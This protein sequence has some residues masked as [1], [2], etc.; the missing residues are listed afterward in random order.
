[1]KMCSCQ[2]C[3]VRRK[4]LPRSVARSRS[5][6]LCA[7]LA[8]FFCAG[9]VLSCASAG[10]L[11]DKADQQARLQTFHRAL[12]NMMLVGDYH[13][14]LGLAQEMLF[15]DSTFVYL[16][17]YHQLYQC[18][19][20][21][22]LVN[23]AWVALHF[24]KW[25]AARV[26]N[27]GK[28]DLAMSAFDSWLGMLRHRFEEGGLAVLDARLGDLLSA[29]TEVVPCLPVGGVAAIQRRVKVPRG[30]RLPSGTVVV[31]AT[32]DERSRVVDCAV[33]TSVHPVWDQAVVEAVYRTF[34]FPAFVKGKP[35]GATT[36][37]EVPVPGR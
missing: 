28:R 11:S 35:V 36:V 2:S 25:R 34:F 16:D 37:V 8:A 12:E 7:W 26:T 31:E 17:D 22:G 24:G 13:G 1:M 30:S 9:V 3:I 27:P 15:L 19:V 29:G 20:R 33:L 21:T 14:A 32:V 10:R 23:T 6:E 5:G 18:G 4:P